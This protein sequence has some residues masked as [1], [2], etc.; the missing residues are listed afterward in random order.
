MSS[1]IPKERNPKDA[2]EEVQSNLQAHFS[3]HILDIESFKDVKEGQT[4][5]GVG[6]LVC[7]CVISAD[8]CLQMKHKRVKAITGGRVCMR[9]R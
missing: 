3:P 4:G 8:W 5:L 7:G 2:Q 1:K 9:V 6:E